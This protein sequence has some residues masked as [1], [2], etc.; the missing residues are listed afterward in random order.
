MI[1]IRVA[2]PIPQ[3]RSDGRNP[4]DNVTGA[5]DAVAPPVNF[6]R[7]YLAAKDVSISGFRKQQEVSRV[8]VERIDGGWGGE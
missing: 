4:G 3:R 6:S 5:T 8:K 1:A 7:V 2:Y